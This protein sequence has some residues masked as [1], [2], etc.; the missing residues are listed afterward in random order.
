MLVYNNSGSKPKL[1]AMRQATFNQI[2]GPDMIAM[3][4]CGM[5]P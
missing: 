1:S 4:D 3:F 2:D 5:I